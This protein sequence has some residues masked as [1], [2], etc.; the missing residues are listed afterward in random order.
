M[1]A[2]TLSAYGLRAALRAGIQRVISQ[3]EEINRINIFPVADHDTGTNMAFTLVAVLQ[4][5]GELRCVRTDEL[6]R[7]VAEDAM[8]GARGNAGAMGLTAPGDG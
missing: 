6:F 5:M 8:D 3:R 1:G 4:G 2:K 7:Q